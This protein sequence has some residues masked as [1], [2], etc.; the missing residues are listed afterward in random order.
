MT[1]I[2]VRSSWTFPSSE[3]KPSVNAFSLSVFVGF[4]EFS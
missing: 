2:A 4:G 3:T 1:P